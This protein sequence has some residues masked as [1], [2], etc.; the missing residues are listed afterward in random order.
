MRMKDM[1]KVNINDVE[2]YLEEEEEEEDRSEGA[3]RED[4]V[5]RKQKTRNRRK[6]EYLIERKK[7]RELLDTDDSYWGD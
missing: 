6:I 5:S 4:R 3:D 7:F 2:S 1:S